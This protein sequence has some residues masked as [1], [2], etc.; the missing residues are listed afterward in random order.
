VFTPLHDPPDHDGDHAVFLVRESSILVMVDGDLGRALTVDEALELTGTKPELVLG[1]TDTTVYWA[2]ELPTHVEPGDLH[3]L[4]GL[5]S[6][7]GVLSDAE[8][9]IGGRATQ[10]SQWY[11]E[12]RFCGR[13]GGPTERS[14]GRAGDA[15]PGRWHERLPP[16]SPPR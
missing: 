14:A 5:R 13:C 7:H 11:R 2:A 12:H 9:N 16:D 6:L 3:R 15:L 8:W 1:R 4:A 10:L